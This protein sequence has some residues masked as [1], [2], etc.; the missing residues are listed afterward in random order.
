M[1]DQWVCQLGSRP[2]RH[3]Q[4]FPSQRQI[5]DSW[6]CDQ[7]IVSKT[8]FVFHFPFFKPM[9]V[10]VNMLL[11]RSKIILSLHESVNP[12]RSQCFAVWMKIQLHLSH[13]STC[14]TP[15][16]CMTPNHSE[17]SAPATSTSTPFP[18]TYRTALWPLTPTFTRV[19]L[20]VQFSL[21]LRGKPN[22]YRI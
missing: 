19:K 7:W 15:G 2:V 10:G 16:G 11:S 20:C 1:V 4:N 22:I 12:L 9:F 14:T 5:L 3:N 21:V 6:H 17:L 8:V 18:S 13:M